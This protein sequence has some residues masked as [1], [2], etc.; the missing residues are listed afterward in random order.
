MKSPLV[1]A[2]FFVRR[3][4]RKDAVRSSV[5]DAAVG[6]ACAENASE[7]IKEVTPEVDEVLD[8]IEQHRL[9]Q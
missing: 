3:H 7:R 9:L 1:L 8:N 2:T 4:E 5:I 6:K